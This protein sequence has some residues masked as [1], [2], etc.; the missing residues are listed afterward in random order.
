MARQ[1]VGGQSLLAIVIDEREFHS[2]FDGF[3]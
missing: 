1:L 3:G 2:D